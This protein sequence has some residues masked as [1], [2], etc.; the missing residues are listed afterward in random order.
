MVFA[1]T[2]P[3]LSCRPPGES[4]NNSAGWLNVDTLEQAC[5]E[6]MISGC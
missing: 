1:L 6:K 2:T 5:T 4:K 3:L